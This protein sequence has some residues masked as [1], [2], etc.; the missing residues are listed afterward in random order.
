MLLGGLFSAFGGANSTQ[1]LVRLNPDG[2]VDTSFTPTPNGI[3]S[4]LLIQTDGK[5]LVAGGFTNIDGV[6]N[7]YL[8]RLNPDGTLDTAYAP[9][10]NLQVLSLELQPDGKI[11]VGGDFGMLTPTGATSTSAFNYMARVNTDGTI[12]TTFNPDLNSPVY[13]ISPARLGQS[14]LESAERSPRRRRTRGRSGLTKRRTSRGSTRTAPWTRPST[15]SPTPRSR[16]S[17]CRATAS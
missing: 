12:D 1:N 6:N 9:Q 4:A 2:S 15:P 16:R 13:A 3:V 7:A 8:A 5:I 11:L 10:P 14:I 17:R